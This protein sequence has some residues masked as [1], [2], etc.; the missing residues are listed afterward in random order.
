MTNTK[1]EIYK[2]LETIRDLPTLPTVVQKLGEMIRDPNSGAARIAGLIED[3]PAIM[4]RILRV[5]NSAFYAGAEKVTSVQHAVARM[6]MRAVNN[7][8]M[9]TSVFSAFGPNDSS[10][11]Q[12]EEFWRHSICTGIAASVVYDKARQNVKL[13][14]SKDILHLAGLLHDIG[15]IVLDEYFNDAFTSALDN[16]KQN[17]IPLLQAEQQT[18][19]VDHTEIGLWLAKKW[20]LSDDLVQVISMHHDPDKTTDEYWGITALCH[21]ANYT[22][23]QQKLGDAGDSESP[24][25][26][27][28]IWK[29]LGLSVADISD[30]VD[31]IEEESSKSEILM[32]FAKEE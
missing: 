7:I 16:A 29:Q 20:Q 4:T 14:Y 11:M 13:R 31:Q 1:N 28:H 2:K 21:I 8:A 19:G 24:S 6:G 30:L 15:K 17:R 32:E 9:S 10:A 22:C 23:N 5:V 25:F 12:R 18:L 3:D 26:S 27:E